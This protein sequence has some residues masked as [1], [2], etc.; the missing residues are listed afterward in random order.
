MSDIVQ[1]LQEE[2]DQAELHDDRERLRELLDDEFVSIGPRGFLL[3]KE[4]WIDRHDEFA[5]ETLETSEMDVRVYD[6]S[7]IVRDVQRNRS[8]YREQ[9]LEFA[10]RVGQVWVQRDGVWK[11][12]A[13]Q[14]SPL[15]EEAAGR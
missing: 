4:Q 3:D 7:A 8:R 5:Y 15:A 14:F 10:F 2:F 9:Q 11:L 13:I 6:G 12:A 1:K